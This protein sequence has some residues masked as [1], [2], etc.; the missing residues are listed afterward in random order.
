MPFRFKIED[1][2]T[3]L[4][5]DAWATACEAVSINTLAVLKEIP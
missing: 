5:S 2:G 3:H 1:V 4:C